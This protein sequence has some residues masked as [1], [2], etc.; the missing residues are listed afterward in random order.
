MTATDDVV[1]DERDDRPGDVVDRLL[2]LALLAVGISAQQVGT[3]PLDPFL[4]VIS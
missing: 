2:S 1:E 4:I 3:K